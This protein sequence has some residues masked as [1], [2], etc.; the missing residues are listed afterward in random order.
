[1]LRILSLLSLLLFATEARSDRTGEDLVTNCKLTYP[2]VT[3]DHRGV[4]CLEYI[5]GFTE[6]MWL[7][8]RTKGPEAALFCL[9]PDAKVDNAVEAVMKYAETHP[10]SQKEHMSV[11]T[12]RALRE[13]FP[14]P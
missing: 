14:C 12:N 7:V 4:Y 2:A 10:E 8:F 6:G 3:G 13:A 5:I 1:M 9:P 11:F